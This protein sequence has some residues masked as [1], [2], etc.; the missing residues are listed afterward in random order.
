MTSAITRSA[1]GEDC[2]VRLVGVCTHN[3]ETVIWSHARW[4]SAGRGKS[5]KAHDLA[6]AYCCTACD[7]AYD[8]QTKP[9]GM[10][11]DEIDADWCQGHFRSLLR[12]AEKGLI[13]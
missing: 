1:R 7:A 8:G 2:T 9:A 11:R 4:G 10:T 12:L 13:K 5:I 3:P 6:G